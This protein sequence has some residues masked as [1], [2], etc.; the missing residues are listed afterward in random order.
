MDPRAVAWEAGGRG[1]GDEPG[2][3]LPLPPHARR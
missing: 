2:V 1:R 3:D